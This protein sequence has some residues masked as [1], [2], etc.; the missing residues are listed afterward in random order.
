MVI[1]DVLWSNKLEND[2]IFEIHNDIR[3]LIVLI[4]LRLFHSARIASGKYIGLSCNLSS[5]IP[6][7][8]VAQCE[9]AGPIT[10]R[11]VDRKYIFE[12]DFSIKMGICRK[13]STPIVF[14]EN[15]RIKLAEL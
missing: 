14:L 15:N 10:Q 2:S 7:K 9:R 6:N 5:R 3:Y 13:T 1:T 12:T 8:R 11:S 4:L